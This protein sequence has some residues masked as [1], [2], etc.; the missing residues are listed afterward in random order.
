M[1]A[2]SVTAMCT[3]NS[4]FNPLRLPSHLHLIYTM[5]N[6]SVQLKKSGLIQSLS[7]DVRKSSVCVLVCAIVETPLPGGLETS[8]H[9]A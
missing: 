1:Q 8:G 5:E 6:G 7:C 4:C 9:R 2:H 3:A